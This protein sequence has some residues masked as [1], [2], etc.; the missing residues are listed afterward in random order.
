MPPSTAIISGTLIPY[1]STFRSKKELY[2]N[3]RAIWFRSFWSRSSDGFSTGPISLD[4]S[5]ARCRS[6]TSRLSIRMSSM[7][8][9]VFGSGQPS[10]ASLS[11]P[12]SLPSPLRGVRQKTKLSIRVA[13]RLSSAIRVLTTSGIVPGYSAASRRIA[14]N[15]RT[16]ISGSCA[17]ALSSRR[18]VRTM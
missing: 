4:T 13:A 9:A 2:P 6:A 10:P 7:S 1:S 14:S 16:W 18:V 5:Q 8:L 11:F 17:R 3:S 15:C 12:L